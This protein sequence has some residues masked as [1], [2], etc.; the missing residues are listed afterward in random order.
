MGDGQE[1]DNRGQVGGYL[2]D[3]GFKA[4]RSLIN[5]S[6]SRKNDG[7]THKI[8]EKCTKQLTSTLLYLA[9]VVFGEGIGGEVQVEGTCSILHPPKIIGKGQHTVLRDKSIAAIISLHS[10]GGGG[11]SSRGAA[12]GEAIARADE[13]GRG[14]KVFGKEHYH[15]PMV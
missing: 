4:S 11:G 14:P 13:K 10:R 5:H 2:E 7:N 12:D 8:V 6:K 3:E 9:M 1:E 15:R